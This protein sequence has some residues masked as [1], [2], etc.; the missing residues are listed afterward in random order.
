MTSGGVPRKQQLQLQAQRPS[1]APSARAV[2]MTAWRCR[3]AWSRVANHR[4]DRGRQSAGGGGTPG[5]RRQSGGGGGGGG[6]GA[7]SGGLRARRWSGGGTGRLK[8]PG[9]PGPPRGGPRARQVVWTRAVVGLQPLCSL[10]P[11]AAVRGCVVRFGS[12]A[13]AA[14]RVC[15]RSL[16]P[17]CGGLR[18]QV[19]GL[20]PR[21]GNLGP[22]V[23]SGCGLNIQ[24]TPR[25]ARGTG[26]GG[27][28]AAYFIY[29]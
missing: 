26:G 23:C 20:N 10:A 12:T 29:L 17:W 21:R 24:I 7:P 13:S 8:P 2:L 4:L 16:D 25:A 18:A 22:S 9:G 3:S 6:P 14:D 19:C 27:S 15:P 5:A 1:S 28:G 11:C